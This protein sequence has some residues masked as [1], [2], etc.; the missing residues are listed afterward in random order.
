MPLTEVASVGTVMIDVSKVQS[1]STLV[2]S[3]VPL[4]DALF[5][6]I[7][8]NRSSPTSVRIAVLSKMKGRCFMLALMYNHTWLPQGH[9][10]YRIFDKFVA[11][12]LAFVPVVSLFK[13]D[14]LV[15]FNVIH[16]S[17]TTLASAEYFQSIEKKKERLYLF[18]IL[19]NYG[20]PI[21]PETRFL[22][23]QAFPI[24]NI[25]KEVSYKFSH[26]VSV[27]YCQK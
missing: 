12:F 20:C 7:K 24:S 21:L 11:L 13:E 9:H 19:T 8:T 16:T 2:S 23:F 26:I 25:I 3:D 4:G 18:S 10:H 1:W 6:W 5:S 17:Y 14:D 22:F 27:G 15:S